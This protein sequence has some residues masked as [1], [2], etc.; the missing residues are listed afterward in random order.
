MD[1]YDP[2]S[3]RLFT[4]SSK[5]AWYLF[6]FTASRNM[7]PML[8]LTTLKGQYE[9]VKQVMKQ[10]K[11]IDHNW[12]ICVDLKTVNFLLGQKSGYTKFLCFLCLWDNRAKDQHYVEWPLRTK[13][14]PGDKKVIDDSL[15]P[16]DKIVFHSLHIK[17]GFMKKFIKVLEKEGNFF[18]YFCNTFS[19]IMGN[20]NFWWSRVHI[21][22]NQWMMLNQELENI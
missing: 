11:Y 22:V 18:E 19:G 6:F 15:F 21:S 7:L 5:L 16:R 8:H 17:L 20:G 13:L 4:D 9:S 12:V 1:E 14:N 2:N 3:C 10:I